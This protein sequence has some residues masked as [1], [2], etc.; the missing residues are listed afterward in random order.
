MHTGARELGPPHAGARVPASELVLLGMHLHAGARAFARWGS[1]FRTL[2][3]VLSHAGARAF[4]RWARVFARC[5]TFTL[6]LVF[7]DFRTLGTCFRTFARW[8]TR[9]C[10]SELDPSSTRTSTTT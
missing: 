4:A 9:N 2:G 6:G 10:S 8:G 5:A 7:Q 3:L 1:C